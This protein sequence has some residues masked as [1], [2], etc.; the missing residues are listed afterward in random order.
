MENN[1]EWKF[2]DVLLPDIRAIFNKFD[3][4]FFQSRLQKKKI[5]IMWS[6]AMGNSLTNRNFNDDQGRYLIALNGPLLTLRPRIE[7]IS[8]ILVCVSYSVYPH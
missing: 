2:I 1:F 5:D 3:A 7:I 8:I 4:L 6:D